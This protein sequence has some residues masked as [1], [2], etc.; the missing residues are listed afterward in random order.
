MVY[1][2]APPFFLVNYVISLGRLERAHLADSGQGFS[3]FIFIFEN[4]SL[5]PFFLQY[6][7][8]LLMRF[9]ECRAG[10]CF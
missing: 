5:V 2:S 4:F 9:M 3:I 8:K 6:H 7:F 10:G 1:G